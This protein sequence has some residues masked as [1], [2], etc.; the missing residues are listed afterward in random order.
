MPKLAASRSPL[1]IH[2]ERAGSFILFDFFRNLS[3]L[4]NRKRDRAGPRLAPWTREKRQSL[5]RTACTPGTAGHPPGRASVASN[6]RARRGA[7]SASPWLSSTT[8][9][10]A[11]TGASV[12]SRH[13]PS[14]LTLEPSDDTNGSK[15]TAASIRGR[16]SRAATVAAPART[17]KSA[18]RPPGIIEQDSL[19]RPILRCRQYHRPI[20]SR[21]HFW[22]NAAS[23]SGGKPEMP[24]VFRRNPG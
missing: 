17:G 1:G 15:W 4:S 8:T 2:R 18:R 13:S 24:A 19:H 20:V 3:R 12:D 11:F 22:C 9:P 16:D 6:S 14:S 10:S 5:S 7:V 23:A 21:P